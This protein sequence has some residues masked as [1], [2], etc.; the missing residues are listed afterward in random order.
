[1]HRG[2]EPAPE[3][4]P[5]AD[6]TPGTAALGDVPAQSAR[7]SPPHAPRGQYLLLGIYRLDCQKP[8]RER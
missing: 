5:G 3:H 7:R 6:A 8:D 4:A 2:T 1:M